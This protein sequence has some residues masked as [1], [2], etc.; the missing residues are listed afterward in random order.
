MDKKKKLVIANWKMNPLAVGEAVRLFDEIRN[1]TNR[2]T[3]VQTVIC[4]PFIFIDA[5]K[6]RVRGHH[7]TVGAQD[8]S[9]EKGTGAHTGEVSVEQLLSLGVSHVIVG[10]S[11]RRSRGETNEIINE[12]LTRVLKNGLVEI[13]CVGERER[14]KEGE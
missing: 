7:C 6:K 1:S 5:L 12:K 13:L 14:G 2:A 8:V 3:L 10:H 4:P 11:E 9:L